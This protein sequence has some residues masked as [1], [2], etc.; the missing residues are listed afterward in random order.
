M[1]RQVPEIMYLKGVGP[2]RAEVL[3]KELG[4]ESVL[5]LVQIYPFRYID[6]SNFIKI[7]D[8]SSSNSY[9]QVKAS[10]QG[11]ELF[12]DKGAIFTQVFNSDSPMISPVPGDFKWHTVKR[13]RVM[14]ADETGSV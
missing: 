12:G 11:I 13:M 14:I 10:V 7:K 2:K 4:V 6:R 1:D 3:K 8:I 5:D 9:I